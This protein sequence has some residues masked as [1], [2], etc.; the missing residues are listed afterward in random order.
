MGSHIAYKGAR[1]ELSTSAG[2]SAMSDEA[3]EIL[4]GMSILSDEELE[5]V[6]EV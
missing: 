1:T 4:E 5:G 2:R 6:A 3:K